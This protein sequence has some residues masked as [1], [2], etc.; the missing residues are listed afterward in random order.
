MSRFTDA[1]F[2]VTA[3]RRR[4]R[5]V[6]RLTSPFVYEVGYLGSG[7]KLEAR[8]GFETDFASIPLLPS[9]FPASIIRVRDWIADKL[10]RSAVAHDLCRSDA[11][12][13]KL[14]GDWIFWEAMG[15]DRVPAWLRAVAFAAVL[16][17]FSRD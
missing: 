15:A 1:T 16:L 11:R 14:L 3:R 13:P 2:E 10:A 5:L 4:G 12:V 17:N 6:V 7:W 8:A 9:W